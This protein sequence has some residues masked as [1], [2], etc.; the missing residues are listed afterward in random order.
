MNIPDT[1]VSVDYF[2]IRLLVNGYGYIATDEDGTVWWYKEE[3]TYS[4]RE[5][6]CSCDIDKLLTVDLEGVDWKD[7]LRPVQDILTL[8]GAS[9]SSRGKGRDVKEALSAFGG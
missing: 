8:S 9:C 3:P 5:W 7:T 6:H 2:G 4:S 1:P